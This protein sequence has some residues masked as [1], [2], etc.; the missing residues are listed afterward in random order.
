MSTTA[1]PR[2]GA[3]AE[4][5]FEA[6]DLCHRQTVDA[7]GKLTELVSR[8]AEQGVDDTARELARDIAQ[9]FDTVARPHHEDEERHVFPGLVAR[10][11]AELTQAVLRL[12]QDH[13]WLEE[14]WLEIGPHIA[15]VA[16]G[17]SW[18]DPALL[19]EGAAVFSA[20]SMEHITLEESLIYPAARAH[21]GTDARRA[22]A[23]E[24]AARRHAARAAAGGRKRGG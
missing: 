15:A 1:S 24:M 11:D 16:A 3:A 21:T 19:A 6:L 8:L 13:D 17:Q 9:H 18:Y 23:R 2:S 20:L 14:D 10:G 7:L 12:Q 5:G 22:M 4:D